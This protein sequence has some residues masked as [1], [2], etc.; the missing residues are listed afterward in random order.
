M[1]LVRSYPTAIGGTQSQII[2]VIIDETVCPHVTVSRTMA[3]PQSFY[4]PLRVKMRT[5]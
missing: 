3:S 5:T 1:S 2:N 4:I